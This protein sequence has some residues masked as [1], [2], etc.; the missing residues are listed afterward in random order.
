MVLSEGPLDRDSLKYFEVHLKLQMC[1]TESV[2]GT[3]TP[4]VR[5]P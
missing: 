5:R 2:G 1:F 3:V 4:T